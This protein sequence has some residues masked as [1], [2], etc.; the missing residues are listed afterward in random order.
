MLYH[1]ATGYCLEPP[2]RAWDSDFFRVYVSPKINVGD[3]RFLGGSIHL[4]LS[5]EVTTV[6]DL[7]WGIT[8]F[9]LFGIIST[10]N[11]FLQAKRRPTLDHGWNAKLDA[12]HMLAGV[13]PFWFVFSF[14][15]SHISCFCMLVVFVV[16]VLC[17]FLFLPKISFE[18]MIVSLP[19]RKVC[20]PWS[21]H[22]VHHFRISLF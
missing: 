8:G 10:R 15:P 5:K 17:C 9:S 6:T 12:C 2:H 18:C 21:R 4:N 14:D 1:W 22:T 13:F 3:I 20:L 19:G 16:V 7:H 11:R